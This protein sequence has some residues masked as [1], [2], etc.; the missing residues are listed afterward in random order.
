ME[1]IVK[2]SLSCEVPDGMT[3]DQMTVSSQILLK[4]PGKVEIPPEESNINFCLHFSLPDSFWISDSAP[5]Y[6]SKLLKINFFIKLYV[7]IF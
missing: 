7:E 4:L 2:G 6:L 1:S 3:Q 5:N